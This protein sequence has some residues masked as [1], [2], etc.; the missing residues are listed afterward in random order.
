VDAVNG[1]CLLL[2]RE[3]LDQVDGFDEAY[4]MY[5]E[6]ADLAWRARR[7]GWTA[8]FV[9]VPGVVHHH[10]LGEQR[11]EGAVLSRQN[12]VRFCF[13]HRG[14]A[15][16]AATALFFLTGAAGRDVRRRQRRELPA[17]WGALRAVWSGPR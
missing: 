8:I 7:N 5:G 15:S 13:L 2:K 4:F 6:E 1:A 9:P 17:L 10:A 3:L 11:G 16:G 14:R 12:F